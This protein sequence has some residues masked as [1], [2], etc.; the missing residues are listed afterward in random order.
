M[1]NNNSENTEAIEKVF[2]KNLSNKANAD[3][4]KFQSEIATAIMQI[5]SRYNLQRPNLNFR[6]YEQYSSYSGNQSFV[7]FEKDSEKM[8]K[9]FF[10]QRSMDQFQEALNNFAWAVQNKDNA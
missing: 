8:I 2:T 3:Q 1:I 4:A 7:S 6:Y 10:A 9:E 5:C